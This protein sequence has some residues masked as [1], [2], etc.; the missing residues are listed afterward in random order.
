MKLEPNPIDVLLA[1][2]EAQLRRRGKD[3]GDSWCYLCGVSGVALSRC[4]CGLSESLRCGK[5]K[6]CDDCRD[7]HR[8]IASQLELMFM[9]KRTARANSRRS[10][11]YRQ[12]R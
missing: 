8:K 5:S 2:C 6:V 9:A 7:A 3:G 1:D 4:D 11:L 12:I 10:R